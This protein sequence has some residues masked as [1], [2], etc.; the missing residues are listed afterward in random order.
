MGRLVTFALQPIHHGSTMKNILIITA[1]L[2]L[3]GA[4]AYFFLMN[5]PQDQPE[6]TSPEIITQA[7]P[8]PAEII[9]KPAAENGLPAKQPT[10]PQ[11]TQSQVSKSPALTLGE[12]D[13]VVRESMSALVGEAEVIQNVVTEN[14]IAKLVATIDALTSRQLSPNHLPVMPPGG[15]LEVTEDTSSSQPMKTAQGD[16]IREY[17]LDPVN[18]RRYSH[19]VEVLESID[20]QDLIAQLQ[21]YQP[22]LEDAFRDLGYPDTSF[23][24]RLQEV[25]GHLLQ[26][27]IPDEPV[28]LIKPEAYY[29]F[30]DPELEA[31]SAGQKLMIRM[32]RGNAQR[33]RSKLADIKT[34]LEQAEFD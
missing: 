5:S 32:G 34:A 19:Y 4:A 33:V 7:A 16:T 31:L 28:R 15:V 17:I 12:S 22:L 18:E 6:L 25:I 21:E 3:G 10:Y 2:L 26:T 11:S 9:E 14:V 29:L 1:I 13:P 8:P 30:A 20:T 24:T 23:G 27:P